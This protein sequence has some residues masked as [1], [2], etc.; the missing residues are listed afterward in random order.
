MQVSR[1][2]SPSRTHKRSLGYDTQKDP[3]ET[4]KWTSNTVAVEPNKCTVRATWKYEVL[5]CTAAPFVHCF[6][7][8]ISD[9]SIHS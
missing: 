8:C 3:V 4:S 2:R 7:I 6:N 5:G 1:T 9:V